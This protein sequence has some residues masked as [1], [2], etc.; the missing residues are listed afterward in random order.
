MLAYIPMSSSRLLYRDV[1]FTTAHSLPIRQ[2]LFLGV[3]IQLPYF[4][5]LAL[6]PACKKPYPASSHVLTSHTEGIFPLYSKRG[7]TREI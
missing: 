7:K 3:L 5:V 6:I 1:D 4:H 2:A